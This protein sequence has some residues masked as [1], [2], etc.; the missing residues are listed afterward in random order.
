MPTPLEYQTADLTATKT[1]DDGR[2]LYT[3]L[4][5][6]A[7]RDRQNEI[8][9]VDGWELDNYRRNPVILD[10]HDQGSIEAIIGRA[11]EVRETEAGIEADIV[12]AGTPRGQLAQALADDGILRAVSVGFRPLDV[13]VPRDMREP[14]QHTRKELW[15]ISA[16]AVPANPD[17]LRLRA[18]REPD[19]PVTKAGRVLSA[20]NEARLREAVA[21]LSDVLAGLAA[22][23]DAA[24]D[25]PAKAIDPTMLALLSAS[26]ETLK[27]RT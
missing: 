15:E 27:G 14:V 22:T 24:P 20:K 3:F 21:L 9:T 4:A 10:S 6:S 16:V 23:D 7:T 18:T 17:A 8:V 19:E 5:T 26:L 12:W 2:R 1:A 25:E 11:I 13:T